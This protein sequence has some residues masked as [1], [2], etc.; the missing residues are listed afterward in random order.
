M[1][2]IRFDS[3][4]EN[5][6]LVISDFFSSD[7]LARSVIVRDIN[8]HLSVIIDEEL[9]DDVKSKV[10]SDLREKIGGYARK[11]ALVVD[12][13]DFS[14]G[15]LLAEAKDHNGIKLLKDKIF[16]IDRRV[17]G[18]DWINIPEKL[19]VGNVS[20]FVFASIKGGV[21]RSTALCV[22][23]AYLSK[24]GLRVLAI[25]FDLE[26]P[27]IGS[28]LLNDNELPELGTLDFLVESQVNG[29]NKKLLQEMIGSSYLGK[30]G[31]RVDVVPAIG[32]ATLRSP[33]N[34]LAKIARAYLE[35]NIDN[36]ETSEIFTLGGKLKKL[37]EMCEVNNSYD[38]ILIDSRAGLHE[39]T[40]AAM[41]AIG[42]NI[43][44]FG[45]NQ[46]QTFQGYK[47]LFAHL[48][49]FP[50]DV[51]ID[52]KDR[53]SF[54]HAKSGRADK[55]KINA[56]QNFKDLC[57]MIKRSDYPLGASL[58]EVITEDDIEFVWDNSNDESIVALSEVTECNVLHILED[59]EYQNFDPISR[60]IVLDDSYYQHTFSDL[61]NYL[62]DQVSKSE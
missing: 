13:N 12:N 59:S 54:V 45:T 20:R 50:S 61:I 47:L 9:T 43:L 31:G 1:N 21:G 5:F 46:P 42:G 4:L 35:K 8:G 33:H 55:E 32:K 26:A 17:V 52:L 22:A 6:F 10:E 37:V 28:M 56:V 36:I 34:A 57:D 39:S 19:H 23:A 41:L 60:E 18:V 49:S 16:F 48:A 58:N 51:A 29:F 15:S 11:Y 40:A 7:T 14:A 38:V 62:D 24:R 30:L 2:E 53:I 44:L 27:G 25:D 3:S